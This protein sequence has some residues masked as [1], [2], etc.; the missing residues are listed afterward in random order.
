MSFYNIQALDNHPPIFWQRLL[1]LAALALI[2]AGD[3]QNFITRFDMHIQNPLNARTFTRSYVS[4]LQYL[5]GERDNSHECLLAQLTGHRPKDTGAAR[6][7]FF[8]N[9]HRRVIVE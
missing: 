3:H 8:A 9:N 4:T 5:W 1:D 7:I 2:L 6:I